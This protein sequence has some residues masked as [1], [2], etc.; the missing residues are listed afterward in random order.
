VQHD[1]DK[2]FLPR[3]E[4]AI[5]FEQNCKQMLINFS[6]GHAEHANRALM[7]GTVYEIAIGNVQ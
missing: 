4:A 7:L 1:V 5:H 6:L 2:V 3:I